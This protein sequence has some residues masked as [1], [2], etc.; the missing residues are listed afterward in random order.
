MRCGCDMLVASLITTDIIVCHTHHQPQLTK[1]AKATA[2]AVKEPVA[3]VVAQ[4]TATSSSPYSDDTGRHVV[5]ER[6]DLLNEV[7]E[8]GN[9]PHLV[10]M[11]TEVER[12]Q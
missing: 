9:H 4:P 5:Q 12:I 1:K 3:A 2:A 11:T 7:V 8:K 10:V 6:G